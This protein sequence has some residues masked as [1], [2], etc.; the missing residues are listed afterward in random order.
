MSLSL[1]FTT[2]GVHIS[3]LLKQAGYQNITIFETAPQL[4][5]KC[6]SR[7]NDGVAFE[8]GFGLNI[9]R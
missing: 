1:R 2:G 8:M 7:F 9:M 4:G 6:M 3:C 5:G